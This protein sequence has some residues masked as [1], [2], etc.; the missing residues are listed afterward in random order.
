MR[1]FPLR[2]PA[3][4]S[5]Q[6]DTVRSCVPAPRIGHAVQRLAGREPPPGVRGGS[7]REQGEVGQVRVAGPGAS[8]GRRPIPLG[9][10]ARDVDE[11]GAKV[12]SRVGRIEAR[13][14]G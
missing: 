14:R 6:R 7:A 3:I 8:R 12:V 10:L 4:S 1:N 9:A 5:N 11:A 13:G 2:P